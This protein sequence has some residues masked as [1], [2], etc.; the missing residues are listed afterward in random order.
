[1]NR[2]E[3][4]RQLEC[5]LENIPENERL[6]AL[7]YYNDYFDEAGVENEQNVIQ[8]LGSPQK[9][10]QSIIDDVRTTNYGDYEEPQGYEDPA[11]QYTQNTYQN[12]S[13]YQSQNTY[14]GMLSNQDVEKRKFKTW[15]IVLIVILLIVT[16]PVWIGLVAGLFGGVVGL[17]GGL[18][19]ILIGIIASG[20]GLTIGGFACC[21]AG[22]MSMMLNPVEGVTC[23]GVG[24]LLAA[25]GIL[26]T[27]LFVLLTFIWLPKL[28]KAIINWVKSLFHRNEG[29]NEI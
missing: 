14:Q 17:L 22:I 8:E 1:M 28:V 4:L 23:M 18:F 9:V 3:F 16:F 13:T 7:A 15:Q 5:L 20:F 21:V 26:L 24:L 25:I 19:G 27:L 12:Q 29:G 6:D 10:A 2:Q 11:G